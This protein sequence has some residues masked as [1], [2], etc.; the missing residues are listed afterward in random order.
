MSNNKL[1]RSS[2]EIYIPPQPGIIDQI[3]DCGGDLDRIAEL[4]SVDPAVSAA[5]IKVV[6]SPA[7][8]R[9]EK[10]GSIPHAVVM[11]GIG[12]ITSI[13]KTLLLKESLNGLESKLDMKMFWKSSVSVASVASTICRQ[14]NL[15]MP[16][17]AYT[18][19]LFHNCGIPVLAARYDNYQQVMEFSY[20]REDGR[21]SSEEFS[22]FGVHH[23]A[24]G[25]RIARVWN[26]PEV[27]C[28]A[29]KNHHSVDRVL[30]DQ[31]IENPTLKTM[32]CVLKMAEHMV[33]LPEK[34]AQSDR[35]FEWE[36]VGAKVLDF[37]GL[38]EYDFEDL[39]DAVKYQ[40]GS[41]F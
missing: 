34:L 38:S 3:N 16:D 17:E 20:S 36:K 26:L 33:N 23:A 7:L 12:R 41:E 2:S 6:N 15:A 37:S 22:N 31:S 24:A 28:K 8:G 18:L 32:L 4:I 40:L 5:I 21:I 14:L 9:T 13:L 19:G 35:D 27:I 25:Y 10:V 1:N 29:V 39:E 30:D 11:L